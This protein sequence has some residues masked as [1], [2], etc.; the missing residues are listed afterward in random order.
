MIET[1]SRQLVKQQTD[2]QIGSI[3]CQKIQKLIKQKL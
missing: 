2:Q 1:G 3:A